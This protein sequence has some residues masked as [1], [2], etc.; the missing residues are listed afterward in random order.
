M[1]KEGPKHN[2]HPATESH[3]HGLCIDQA[4]AAAE[5]VCR[6]RGAR[7]TP[8]RRQVLALIWRSH[9]PVGAY[10][11]MDALRSQG[12]NAAPPTVYR[13]LEFLLTNGLIHRLETLNAYL[14]CPD[15]RQSHQGQYLI[16]EQCGSAEEMA[17]PAVTDL[18]NQLAA[19]RGFATERQTVELFGRCR[20]CRP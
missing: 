7:L 16:C 11:L 2:R 3:D 5:D 20:Q 6:L 10:A 13:A 17:D 9:E 18:L 4:L 15:P 14:G 8:M 19:A 1:A 12:V